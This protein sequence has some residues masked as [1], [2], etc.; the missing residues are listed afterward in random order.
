MWNYLLTNRIRFFEVTSKCIF[1]NSTYGIREIWYINHRQCESALPRH[2]ARVLRRFA[3]DNVTAKSSI[4]S[5]PENAIT[6]PP[7][8]C[9]PLPRCSW[10]WPPTESSTQCCCCRS[11]NVRDI[12]ARVFKTT[13]VC[14]YLPTHQPTYQPI[15]PPSVCT[16]LKTIY[17]D[18]PA[19]S[20]DWKNIYYTFRQLKND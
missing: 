7:P 4:A 3:F 9:N 11:K 17:S 18:I 5:I 2:S 6:L 19:A 16:K 12:F 8:V 15:Y 20:L 10:G 13:K 1:S 14:T